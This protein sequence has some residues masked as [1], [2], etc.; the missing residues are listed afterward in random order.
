MSPHR[1]P[2]EVIPDGPEPLQQ[3]PSERCPACKSKRKLDYSGMFAARIAG[4]Y[5]NESALVM[6]RACT[7]G[8]RVQTGTDRRPVV[9][10]FLWFWTRVIEVPVPVVCAMPGEHL[11][12]RCKVCGHEWLTAFA[13]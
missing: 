10:P 2:G 7:P 9:Q 5:D 1:T 4:G 6:P 3:G 13:E 11:H 8:R 12:E